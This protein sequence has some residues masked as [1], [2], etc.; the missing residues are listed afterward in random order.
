MKKTHSL[1]R[2]GMI[3]NFNEEGVKMEESVND[4]QYPPA[5]PKVGKWYVIALTKQCMEDNELSKDQRYQIVKAGE[6]YFEND[7]FEFELEEVDGWIPRPT[8]KKP[9]K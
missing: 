3:W 7:M 6:H 4:W 2:Q 8:F 5:Q 9:V 1:N